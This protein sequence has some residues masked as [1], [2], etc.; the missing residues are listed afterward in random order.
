MRRCCRRAG[1][2]FD[3]WYHIEHA[4][5]KTLAQQLAEFSPIASEPQAIGNLEWWAYWRL[6]HLNPLPYFVTGLLLHAICTLLIFLVS[7]ELGLGFRGGVIAATWFGLNPA[8]FHTV[9][10]ISTT[11]EYPYALVFCMLTLICYLRGVIRPQTVRWILC[12][13]F[14]SFLSSGDQSQNAVSLPAVPVS[15]AGNRQS[16]HAGKIVQDLV[17]G[18][19]RESIATI[20]LLGDFLW[21]TH[22]YCFPRAG[23]ELT[24]YRSTR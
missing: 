1:L 9:S 3:D 10:W 18:I 12:S 24:G 21:Y 4:S 15:G 14:G 2:Y 5:Q 8:L 7:K 6:F 22:G 16:V 13:Y 17:Q 20:A 11:T 23:P 19:G